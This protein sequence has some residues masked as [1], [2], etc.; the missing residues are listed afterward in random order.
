MDKLTLDSYGQI[1]RLLSSPLVFTLGL[2]LFD[3]MLMVVHKD[4]N[5]IKIEKAL[6]F[7]GNLFNIRNV[8]Y[9]DTYTRAGSSHR[10]EI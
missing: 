5:F 4:K 2:A 6:S 3:N 10:H 7:N 1:Y 9:P 8:N